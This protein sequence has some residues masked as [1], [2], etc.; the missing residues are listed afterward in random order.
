M[1][2]LILGASG[3]LGSSLVKA[4]KE[5]KEIIQFPLFRKNSRNIFKKNKN[6]KPIICKLINLDK[7]D[8]IFKEKKPDFVINCISS[9]NIDL[10]DEK[11]FF[12]LNSF[13]PQSINFLCVK[14]SSKFI[15]ISSDGVFSG[16]RGNYD[17]EDFPDATDIYGLSKFLGETYN[18]NSIVLRTSFIGHEY[19]NKKGLLEWFLDQKECYGFDNHIYSGLTSNFLATIIRDE[20]ITRPELKGIFNLSA[21]PITKYSLLS[22][23]SKIYNTDIIIKKLSGKKINRALSNKKFVNLTKFNFPNWKEMIT[24]MK[25]DN[26]SE[27]K[28]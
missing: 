3:M 26:D 4:F 21:K 16:L 13:L 5:K 17:E 6:I 8:R 2:I 15:N 10:K 9:R 7:L 23:I 14:Y 18:D 11:A 24:K 1:K 25:E 20:I 19:F 12:E 27:K 28:V 22:L